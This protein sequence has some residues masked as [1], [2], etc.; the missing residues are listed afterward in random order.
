[1]FVAEGR[2]ASFQLSLTYGVEHCLNFT[3]KRHN[4]HFSQR[5]LPERT[6]QDVCQGAV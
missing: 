2:V 3:Q 5:V 1:M 6:E 4:L